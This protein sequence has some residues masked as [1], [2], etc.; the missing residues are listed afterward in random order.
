MFTTE[1]L[2]ETAA[3]DNHMHFKDALKQILKS[4]VVGTPGYD[5][6]QNY[7]K[8]EIKNLG[9]TLEL[10]EFKDTAPHFGELKFTNIIGK[11][12]PN[13]DKFVTF[14]C[15]YD[16]KYVKEHAFVGATDS[17]VPC[18]MLL[19]LVKTTQSTLNNMRNNTDISLMV[20][21]TENYSF[22]K[23]KLQANP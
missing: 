22:N 19:N 1:Q 2:K 5:E 23:K 9:L 14:A 13:A 16:S 11:L 3:K 21:M 17:A 4:R 20:S 7:I 12:N 15:H 6:V 10:D 8:D 18:A